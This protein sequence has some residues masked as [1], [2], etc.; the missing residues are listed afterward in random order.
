MPTSNKQSQQH[1]E[2]LTAASQLFDEILLST[3]ARH[4]SHSQT[5]ESSNNSINNNTLPTHTPLATNSSMFNIS[6]NINSTPRNDMN[7]NTTTITNHNNSQ[8]QHPHSQQPSQ[9]SIS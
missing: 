1:D 3:L 6:T 2:E 4:N 8:Q 9:T 7:N 5:H